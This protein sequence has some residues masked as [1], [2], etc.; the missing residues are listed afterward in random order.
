M[1]P[2]RYSHPEQREGPVDAAG[3]PALEALRCQRLVEPSDPE[4][5]DSGRQGRPGVSALKL[6]NMAAA[7]TYENHQR[8]LLAS[9]ERWRSIGPQFV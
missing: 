8:A 7:E 9:R 2:C 6:L 1:R 3:V 5:R 4:A